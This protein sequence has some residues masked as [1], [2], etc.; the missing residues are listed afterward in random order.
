MSNISCVCPSS[1]V[2]IG[3]TKV[4]KIT[5]DSFSSTTLL[6]LSVLYTESGL[7]QAIIAHKI[8]HNQK[9]S[10]RTKCHLAKAQ[11]HWLVPHPCEWV[12]HDKRYH[13][14]NHVLLIGSRRTQLNGTQTL[15]KSMTRFVCKARVR[16]AGKYKLVPC[17]HKIKCMHTHSRAHTHVHAY[18]HIHQDTGKLLAAY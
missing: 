18:K 16:A 4:L 2:K 12:V 8:A 14:L 10:C 15:L 1:T 7:T 5:Q 3:K 9:H 13:W 6:N 17:T 11:L